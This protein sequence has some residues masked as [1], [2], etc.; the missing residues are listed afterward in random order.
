MLQEGVTGLVVLDDCIIVYSIFSW[1]V[2]DTEG[3]ELK[4]SS[5]IEPMMIVRIE[6]RG[7]NH[8]NIIRNREKRY[9]ICAVCLKSK[10]IF[11][12]Y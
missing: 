5:E 12:N 10:L 2:L 11:I 7:T 8:V 6:A 4:R 1:A 9:K 3:R